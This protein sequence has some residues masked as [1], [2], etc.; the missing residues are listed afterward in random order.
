MERVRFCVQNI[1]GGVCCLLCLIAVGVPLCTIMSFAACQPM[2]VWERVSVRAVIDYSTFGVAAGR[3]P[4]V[5]ASSRCL[6]CA[7]PWQARCSLA[8]GPKFPCPPDTVPPWGRCPGS[9][10]LA[11]S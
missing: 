6:A 7:E 2:Q 3:V 9:L 4:A 5:G 11:G 10:G 8:A 1:D